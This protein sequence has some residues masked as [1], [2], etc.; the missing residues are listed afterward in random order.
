[1]LLAPG[2]V[3]TRDFL[4]TNPCHTYKRVSTN[5]SSPLYKQKQLMVIV[6]GLRLNKKNKNKN[7]T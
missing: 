1:V 7:N 4:A 5:R 2:W 6:A 3:T